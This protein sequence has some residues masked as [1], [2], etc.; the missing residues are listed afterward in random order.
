[1]EKGVRESLSPEDQEYSM[2]MQYMMDLLIPGCWN[3]YLSFG[4]H[5]NFFF[6][7]AFTCFVPPESSSE[8]CMRKAVGTP[9]SELACRP[10]AKAFDKC[11]QHSYHLI[12]P[13]V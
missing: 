7:F 4:V 6:F 10:K 8:M 5:P 9:K 13:L 3:E 12:T 1:M 11:L 2:E